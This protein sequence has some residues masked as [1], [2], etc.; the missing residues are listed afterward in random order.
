MT[1]LPILY[2]FRR[3]PY[4]MRARM[5]LLISGEPCWIREILLRDKPPEMIAASGKGTVPILLLPDGRLIDQSLDIMRWTLARHDPENWLGGDDHEIIATND[6]PFKAHLDGYKYP[7]RLEVD[8][9]VHRAAGL[10]ILGRLE[11]RLAGSANLCGDTRS[12]TDI[13]VMPFVRQFAAID[14]TWFDAQPLG[15]VREWLSRHMAS[16]LFEQAM[17][18]LPPWNPDARPTRLGRLPD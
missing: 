6:G 1:D 5:A 18:R 9:V 8:P 14:R 10:E 3:C 11:D 7:G 15:R 4:A 13:A 17:L 12:L 2:S 16:S